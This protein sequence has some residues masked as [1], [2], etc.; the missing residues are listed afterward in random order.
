MSLTKTR[1]MFAMLK[2]EKSAG[3]VDGRHL[4]SL[5]YSCSVFEMWR[6][7]KWKVG[8]PSLQIISELVHKINFPFQAAVTVSYIFGDT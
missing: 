2:R 8:I 5:N 7:N 3:Y 4:P 1:E 6:K